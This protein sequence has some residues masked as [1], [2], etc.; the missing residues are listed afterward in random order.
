MQGTRTREILIPYIYIYIWNSRMKIRL[1]MVYVHIIHFW[2]VI[3]DGC[4]FSGCHIKSD[5]LE[6]LTPSQEKWRWIP[7]SCLGSGSPWFFLYFRKKIVPKRFPDCLKRCF[8]E[9]LRPAWLITLVST[10][11]K[12]HQF[13]CFHLYHHSDWFRIG[14]YSS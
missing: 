2:W 10:A 8:P 9:L 6:Q 4:S 12:S 11:S 5:R 13:V 1:G 7:K 3:R 14:F